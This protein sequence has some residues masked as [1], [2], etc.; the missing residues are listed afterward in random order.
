VCVCVK[1]LSRVVKF[2]TSLDALW[3]FFVT[4][5]IGTL[6]DDFVWA[7][8]HRDFPCLVAVAAY[9]SC[10]NASF[11]ANKPLCSLI[12]ESLCWMRRTWR[13]ACGVCVL[14][15]HLSVQGLR[16]DRIRSFFFDSIA[17]SEGF[18][19]QF[20]PW[21]GEIFFETV[22]EPFHFCV[23][24]NDTKNVITDLNVSAE[25]RTILIRST[26]SI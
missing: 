12:R 19:Q 7:G 1:R 3:P 22:L 17:T 4:G 13:D 8:D 16:L 11:D 24:N 9:Y 25:K 14:A 6:R 20:S 21:I 23:K 15:R 18:C 10:M 26:K 5:N 2:I